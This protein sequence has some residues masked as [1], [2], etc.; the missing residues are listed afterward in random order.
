M[1]ARNRSWRLCRHDVVALR[2]SS[3]QSEDDVWTKPISSGR[4]SDHTVSLVCQ[5]GHLNGDELDTLLDRIR[6][7]QTYT[8]VGSMLEPK[9]SDKPQTGCNIVC[10]LFWEFILTTLS[11]KLSQKYSKSQALVNK[12]K[13]EYAPS[14][15]FLVHIGS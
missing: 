10:F 14:C 6:S 11:Q 1:V 12:K 7:G 15:V 13:D 9:E 5:D 8:L 4:S 3:S 2:P